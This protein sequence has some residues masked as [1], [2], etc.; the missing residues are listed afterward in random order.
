MSSTE[1][2]L[3]DM[4]SQQ[5]VHAYDPD[6]EKF[7]RGGVGAEEA[8][9]G[10]YKQGAALQDQSKNSLAAG[11]TQA[12]QTAQQ[13]VAGLAMARHDAGAAQQAGATAQANQLSTGKGYAGRGFS[14]QY[15]DNPQL[16]TDGSHAAMNAQYEALRGVQG[17]TQQGADTTQLNNFVSSARPQTEALQNFYQQGPG[18]SAAQ[19]QL[20]TGADASMAQALA[21][22]RSGRNGA[23]PAAERQA[24]FQNGATMQQLSGQQAALRANEEQAWR[25][26]KLQAMT[27]EQQ[28]RAQ[29]QGLQLGGLQSAQQAQEQA[30]GQ[31]LQAMGLQQQ[32]LSGI[33]QQSLAQSQA[34][35][36][37]ALAGRAQNDQQ[38][39]GYAN[40]SN[41]ANALGYQAGLGYGNLANQTQATGN[42]Y[43]LG[44]GSLAN[45]QQGLGN[46]LYGTQQQI[47]MGYN[48][49]GES[50]L[51]A[52]RNANVQEES[53]RSQNIM[54]AQQANSGYD[55]Q[56][57]QGNSGMMMAGIG[58]LAMLSD[59][60]EKQGV[61]KEFGIGNALMGLSGYGDDWNKGVAA[62]SAFSDPYG[63]DV[64]RYQAPQ[65]PPP[66]KQDNS[67][68]GGMMG[69]AMAGMMSS[70]RRTK[71]KVKKL[72][73]E[74]ARTYEA[75]GGAPATAGVR[76]RD[77][78]TDALDAAQ[79]APEVD[80]RPAQGYSYE[81]KNPDRPGAGAGRFSG[82][83]AQDLERS[84]ATAGTVFSGPDGTKR[85]DPGRLTMVN[86]S[87]I[88][89]QQRR[90]DEL[91]AQLEA[92]GASKKREFEGISRSSGRQ[93]GSPKRRTQPASDAEMPPVDTSAYF[94]SA[95][96]GF[97][98]DPS[99]NAERGRRAVLADRAAH[100]DIDPA[101]HIDP[102]P[103]VSAG[104]SF[105]RGAVSG[106]LDTAAFPV[107]AVGA[108][109]EAL[110][111]PNAAAHLSG[112][113]AAE[114]LEY[115]TAGRD[116]AEIRNEE[117]YANYA[118]PE[119][120]AAGSLVG[121]YLGGAPI[122]A[123]TGR[124]PTLGPVL[125]AA[126][127]PRTG[128]AAEA[129]SR[130]VA[131]GAAEEHTTEASQYWQEHPEHAEA[132]E[133]SAKFYDTHPEREQVVRS[134]ENNSALNKY[135]RTKEAEKQRL[136]ERWRPDVADEE[137][138]NKTNRGLEDALDAGHRFPDP[139]YRSLNLPKEVL[140]DWLSRGYV[141][142]DSILSTT[143][144]P[145]YDASVPEKYGAGVPI[146]MR[147]EPGH[148]VP[149]AGVSK[150]PHEQEV[151]IPSGRNWQIAGSH[152]DDKGRTVLDMRYVANV[153]AGT[154]PAV[155]FA[156]G[157]AQSSAGLSAATIHELGR[158]SRKEAR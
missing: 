58:A 31:Q 126:R 90:I 89:E 33:G 112:Q 111:Y 80:L 73:G 70:D 132:F 11:Q 151:M 67:M 63:L 26:Q 6:H 144:S 36:Q 28:A 109:A 50:T 108:A 40:L 125:H 135:L 130:R 41:Q 7:Q 116:P 158:N 84:P 71:D 62:G 120:H 19:A 147:L 35:G 92:L 139:S 1:G 153:P 2:I 13:G 5:E 128:K 69:G 15:R 96:S 123:L 42:Q 3:S 44:Q 14:A 75:L 72:D 59:E 8:A 129:L 133:R 68:M 101:Y 146:V 49:M 145:K 149:I 115:L 10:Y 106:A 39:L 98:W 29:S 105:A 17:Q 18:P 114:N 57:D 46:Q 27:A 61:S 48:Q 52:E 150:F 55:A 131:R 60:R 140:Q 154:V 82:P 124:V 20:Q 54:A 78:D 122:A 43:A 37:L 88:S 119:A 30:R 4:F 22:S 85:V 79:R 64:Q 34:S 16:N 21:L 156:G 76:S 155:T 107:K 24:M 102:A 136:G 100:E 23:N 95:G 103:P 83:M 93:A 65:A 138:A 45:Q 87:A 127:K 74:F 9:Q 110:G 134:T 121:E 99:Y 51:Q 91:S 32:T 12:A 77:V 113:E 94:P 148:G 152:V 143:A 53:M 104:R 38:A 56:R 142:N 66:Q 47:G 118:I 117:A 157:A 137:R 25:G 86:T 81:Y 141:R 97:R